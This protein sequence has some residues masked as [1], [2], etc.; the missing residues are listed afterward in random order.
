MPKL[1]ILIGRDVRC[2]IRAQEKG[3]GAREKREELLFGGEKKKHNCQTV[4]KLRPFVLLIE[5]L[6]K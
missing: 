3:G 1:S 2:S 5:I 4:S 6:W